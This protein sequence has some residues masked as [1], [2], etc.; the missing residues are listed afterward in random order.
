M[1]QKTSLGIIV[2]HDFQKLHGFKIQRFLILAI[3]RLGWHLRLC[4]SVAVKAISACRLGVEEA[5]SEAVSMET[6]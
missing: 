3:Q 2:L 5:R 4:A 6:A 1:E